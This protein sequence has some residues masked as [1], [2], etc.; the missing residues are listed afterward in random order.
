MEVNSSPALL[1]VVPPEVAG[2]NVNFCKNPGCLNCPAW[3]R[4][5]EWFKAE[6][7]PD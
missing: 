2:I 1:P 4:V 5:R 7:R 3:T 6:L